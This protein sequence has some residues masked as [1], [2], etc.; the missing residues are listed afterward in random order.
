MEAHADS[1]QRHSA[2]CGRNSNFRFQIPDASVRTIPPM[3]NLCAL[4][5]RVP[6]PAC[7][8]PHGQRTRFHSDHSSRRSLADP[9]ESDRCCCAP[10]KPQARAGADS[11]SMASAISRRERQIIPVA[12]P[13]ADGNPRLQK[14]TVCANRGSPFALRRTGPTMLRQARR[15]PGC[16]GI[17]HPENG[18]KSL[19][20]PACFGI[21]WLSTQGHRIRN[22]VVPNGVAGGRQR[23]HP[24]P[25]N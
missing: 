6:D 9:P 22:R 7:L 24:V 2:A 16:S 5:I 12:G 4:Q 10:R 21:C 23:F 13:S 18:E 14:S 1:P 25:N 17:I 11:G 20:Q 15:N 8:N 3:E 19:S